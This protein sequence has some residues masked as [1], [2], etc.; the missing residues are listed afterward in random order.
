MEGLLCAR[1]F[2]PHNKSIVNKH[3][4][5]AGFQFSFFSPQNLSFL[6]GDS[7]SAPRTFVETTGKKKLYSHWTH[8]NRS[9]EHPLSKTETNAQ[10]AEQ[11]SVA[12]EPPGFSRAWKSLWAFPFR[13][14]TYSPLL[15]SI[16]VGGFFF[17]N[18]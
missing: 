10:G 7:P 1:N 13:E 6:E 12:L 15:K 14:P 16:W 9:F 17:F 11:T 3:I 8:E 18:S 5:P 2:N 4:S